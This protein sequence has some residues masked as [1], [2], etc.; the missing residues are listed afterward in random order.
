MNRRNLVVVAKYTAIII[1][2]VVTAFPIYWI[3]LGSL[4]PSDR[5]ISHSLSN[6][7]P[8]GLTLEHYKAVL[9]HSNFKN[10]FV[11][12]FIVAGITTILSLII[13]TFAGYSLSR[14]RF[15]GRRLIGRLVLFTYIVPSVLLVVPI[16]IL[17]VALNLSNTRTGLVLTYLTFSL[18]FGIW[19]MRGFFADIPIELEEAAMVDGASRF[20]AMW[21]VVFPLAVPGM[22]AM[23]MFCFLNA[24]NEYLFALVLTTSESIRTIPV[25]VVATFVN[26][27]MEPYLWSRLMAASVLSSIPV[28]I[29]FI[30]L[31]RFL[32]QGLG[33]GAVKG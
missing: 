28:F 16:F 1:I 24:W 7:V 11:N 21:R 31:Q 12:S 20:K 8:V 2:A 3:T 14:L 22:V 25:G 15:R 33:A 30:G 18:P 4:L 9:F 27:N 6:L 17:I 5:L 29:I 10:Y 13:S 32:I 19:I 23:A 26:P